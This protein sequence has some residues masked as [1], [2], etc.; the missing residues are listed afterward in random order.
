MMF[1]VVGVARQLV[2]LGYNAAKKMFSKMVGGTEV[3]VDEVVAQVDWLENL[4][5]TDSDSER[6][7]RSTRRHFVFEDLQLTP[8]SQQQLTT[9]QGQ[10]QQQAGYVFTQV[11]YWDGR[12]TDNNHDR[13]TAQTT[14][15]NRL[16]DK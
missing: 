6:E 10:Q 4:V 12:T 3:N 13:S 14:K 7:E 9:R 8:E 11:S 5:A 15:Q 2:P 1:V 16:P